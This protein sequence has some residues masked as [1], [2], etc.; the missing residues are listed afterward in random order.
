MQSK[1]FQ[2][3]S[4][5]F[6]NIQLTLTESTMSKKTAKIFFFNERLNSANFRVYLQCIRQIQS[7]N[8]FSI[9]RKLF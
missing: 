3:T 5:K 1:P 9:F 8:L 7:K 6:T 4:Y 2:K